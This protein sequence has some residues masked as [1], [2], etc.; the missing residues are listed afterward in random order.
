METLI[1]E[2]TNLLGVKKSLPM[3]DTDQEKDT[4]AKIPLE[5]LKAKCQQ[6]CREYSKQNYW[7]AVYLDGEMI[8]DSCPAD[9]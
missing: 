4:L 3:Y 8:A 2:Y 9:L 5:A 6:I 7:T 1:F